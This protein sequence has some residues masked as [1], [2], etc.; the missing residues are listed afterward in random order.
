MLLTELCGQITRENALFEHGVPGYTNVNPFAGVPVIEL[1][2]RMLQIAD[3]SI[4]CRACH[5][6]SKLRDLVKLTG[7]L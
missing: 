2:L 6:R 1:A 7:F 4:V 5:D 3:M